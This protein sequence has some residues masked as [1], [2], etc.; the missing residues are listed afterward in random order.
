MLSE[1]D[2]LGWDAIDKTAKEAG[3]Y[4]APPKRPLVIEHDYRA[5]TKYCREKN[6]SKMDMT[7]DEIKMFEYP[8]PLVYA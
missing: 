2:R 1:D 8:E 5:M 3:G 4:L 6:I 7:E